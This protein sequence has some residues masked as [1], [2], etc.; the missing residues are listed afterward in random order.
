M[1][2][3]QSLFDDLDLEL[4]TPEQIEQALLAEQAEKPPA[5]TRRPP[6]K[7]TK[8]QQSTRSGALAVQAFYQAYPDA[9]VR[10]L[11]SLLLRS[12]ALPKIDVN[13]S[14]PVQSGLR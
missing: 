3:P 12:S 6:V 4:P 1:P 5:T 2:I 9:V 7:A 14:N 10:G 13:A 8:S 11:K